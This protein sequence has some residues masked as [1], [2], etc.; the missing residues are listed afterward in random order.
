[1]ETVTA[2]TKRVLSDT[3]NTT[4]LVTSRTPLRID[5]EHRFT[6]APLA[7]PAADNSSEIAWH[8]SPAIQL[9]LARARASDDR[10]A[11]TSEAD[12]QIITRLCERLDGLPLALEL[13]AARTRQLSLEAIETRLA[14]SYHLVATRQLNVPER[15][16]TLTATLEWAYNALSPFGR[17]LLRGVSVF[18]GSFAA[19]AVEAVV[20]DD[21]E[22]FD[23]LAELEEQSL[24]VRRRD[25]VGGPP[26]YSL[27]RTIADFASQKLVESGTED[28]IRAQHA[29]YFVRFVRQYGG[30]KITRSKEEAGAFDIL[31]REMPNLRGAWSYWESTKNATTLAVFVS[32]LADFLRRRGHSRERLLWPQIVLKY[33]TGVSSISL[34]VRERLHHMYALALR[35]AAKMDAAEAETLAMQSDAERIGDTNMIADALALRGVIAAQTKRFAE[36]EQFLDQ[37]LSIYTKNENERGEAS[38]AN[39]RAYIRVDGRGYGTRPK[40]V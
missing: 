7:L 38:V 13:A 19:E 22:A 33:V 12:R 40:A 14:E 32:D 23:M 27:L 31:D 30:R 10:F 24:I 9:F 11:V 1:M 28:R 18:V 3:P 34:D 6:V 15:Q 39:N 37:A 16:R 17:E 25:V 26:R 5:A 29:D 8:E 4:I 35:D 20:G 2:F 36:A 21:T